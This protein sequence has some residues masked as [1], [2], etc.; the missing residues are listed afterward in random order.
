MPSAIVGSLRV[1]LGMDSAEFARGAKSAQS[2][3][4]MLG[5]RLVAFGAVATAA[6]GA[7]GVAAIAGANHIDRL[8]K[9][10]RRVDTGVGGFR[11]LELAA[12]EAGVSV[13]TLADAV[14][15]MDREVAKGS[16]NAQSA[17][18]SLGLS[19]RDLEGLEADQKMALIGDSIQKMGLSTAQTS[20][21]LQQLGV[22]NREMVL[23]VGAGGEA[24]RKAR[25]DVEDYGLSVS[26]FDA[27]RIEAANDAIG[28]LGL[29]SEYA[30]QQ[31]ALKIVPALGAMAQAMTDSLRE[32]GLLR[33][34]IDGVIDNL[35]RLAVYAATAAAVMGGQFVFAFVAARGATVLLA[36]AFG[37]L[38]KAIFT[39]GIGAIVVVAGE[40]V[41]QF[42]RL[43]KA[44][45]SIGEAMTLLGDLAREVFGQRMPDLLRGIGYITDGVGAT[46]RGSILGALADIVDGVPEFANKVIGVFVGA[47]DAAIAAW[48]ALPG[49][50]KAIIGE[51]M[52]GVIKGVQAGVAGLVSALNVI[53]GIDLAPPDLSDWL[54]KVEDVTSA[55]GAAKTAFD[56]AFGADYTGAL[57]N[58]LRGMA[59]G[60]TALGDGY[61]EMGNGLIEG[62]TSSLGSWD[63]LKAAVAEVPDAL[64]DVTTSGSDASGVL[65]DIGG[66]GGGKGSAG[67]A[68]AGMKAA[69][70]GAKKLA[71]EIERLEFD[72][73]PLKKYNAELAHLG[74]LSAAGLSDGAYAKAVQDLNDGLA[75]SYPLI[76][77]VAD[78]FGDF[79]AGG[80][81]DF[82]SFVDSILGSF[83]SM[84][85]EMIATAARNKI[86][87]SM[88]IG[89]GG[90]GAAASAM[91]GGSGIGGMLGGIGSSFMGGASGVL[92]GVMSGG[93]SGGLGAVGTA[94]SGATAGLGGLAAAA[95]AVALPLAAVYGAFKF[96]TGSTK[97][98]DAG[99]RLNIEGNEL[100]A[101]SYKNV[102][103]SRFFGL[104]KS[105]KQSYS[106]MDGGGLSDAYAAIYAG[107][108][109]AAWALGLSSKAL[110]GYTDTIHV[111]T[112]GMDEA[113]AQAAVMAALQE[114]QNGLAAEFFDALGKGSRRLIADGE[115]LGAAMDRV[116]LSVVAT[117]PLFDALGGNIARMGLAGANASTQFVAAI[118]GLDQAAGAV[119]NYID[120]FFS[121]REKIKVIEG[122]VRRGL[123]SAGLLNATPQNGDQFRALV[124]RQLAAGNAENAA[125][126]IRLAP[127]F[128][129]WVTMRQ[130]A[131]A[132]E[133]QAQ[134]EGLARIAA[135]ASERDGLWAELDQVRG[136]T[137]KIRERE[138][139][140]LEPSNRAL[141]R[142]IYAVQDATQAE[143]AA[144]TAASELAQTQKAI[145]SERM[146]IQRQIWQLMGNETA[147]RVDALSGLD[148]SNRALQRQYWALSDQKDAQEDLAKASEDATSA[149]Q[150][151]IDAVDP[152]KF[153]TRFSYE[154][155]LGQAGGGLATSRTTA[156]GVPLVSVPASSPAAQQNKAMVSELA[157]LREQVKALVALSINSNADVRKI[158]QNSD[159][160]Q[161]IGT[162]AVRTAS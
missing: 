17:L 88:G 16:K 44:T 122:D 31:L 127:T 66:G 32:G 35:D 162:P 139:A 156:T 93:L 60:A 85:S 133:T 21:V 124:D 150:K 112:K 46:M 96:F 5:K 47:K 95:G 63:A 25:A 134:R 108:E 62:A 161:A 100:L 52:N 78:A 75:D 72:A 39:T 87:L 153:A 80:L 144:A 74:E 151:M 92:S 77:D 130:D 111:S 125:I 59:E 11:A 160:D 142:R 157:A 2:S 113:Q 18:K 38:K 155:A 43:V 102:Q 152:A 14:Q 4:D 23:A 42:V 91:G 159:R 99:I 135:A 6:V 30:G 82:D 49:A 115:E 27:S 61:I 29:I 53:P 103:R 97:E 132:S 114:T 141:Q 110:K 90:V 119:G 34:M 71:D 109:Q 9:A 89:G 48:K 131:L 73:D 145:A 128:D 117:S 106:E 107:A 149:I 65:D 10:G 137:G 136:L 24:F 28:R 86:M 146:G 84:L 7:I 54:V 26:K 129:Q 158:R 154:R 45:G 8:A 138:L 41:F 76:N 22:R 123:N 143:Q 50:L 13:A 58:N 12:G 105:T 83:K 68:A 19:A 69:A 81:R 147:L 20:V 67:K 79:V 140:A 15:T 148:A 101:K 126:L 64:D 40:A 33:I 37:L 116:R 70:A 57:A 118:G 51:A 121:Q 55:T 94:L 104:S 3:A 98:L 120:L 56:A 36:G 1:N